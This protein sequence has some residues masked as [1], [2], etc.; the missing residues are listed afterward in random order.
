MNRQ[1][2][3]SAFTI[4]ELLIVIVVIAILASI[5]IVA[6]NGIQQRARTTAL[7][8]DAR[9]VR[10]QLELIKI[11]TG[12]Y[13]ATLSA[14]SVSLS[15][16]NTFQYRTTGQ[17]YCVQIENPQSGAYFT[18][19]T[20]VS[21][22]G[23]CP[24]AHYKLD[25]NAEDSSIYTN[26]GTNT[27]ATATSD[28]FGASGG[29]LAFNGTSSRINISSAPIMNV[30]R[31]NMTISAW[32]NPTA[33]SGT[34]AVVNRNAPYLLWVDAGR[35]MNT[36]LSN[37]TWYWHA[38]GANTLELSKWQHIA[39]TYNGS[40]RKLYINGVQVGSGDTQISGNINSN[41]TGI[42][43]GYDSC[44]SRNYFNGS[45]DDVRIYDEELTSTEIKQLFE[46]TQ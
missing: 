18:S 35:Q 9:M 1:K 34:H 25:G 31:P 7:Q 16:G 41:S 24:I 6:Y 42:A 4:V 37:G 11:D 46:A 26:N 5:S 22:A 23:P 17:D 38:S 12:S 39:F 2:Q 19:S 43:I 32:I 21:S 33:L 13:P 14:S 30:G 36:G 45:I 44:C 20:G 29:A 40:V 8:S 15:A 3:N 10:T 27:G 28:R